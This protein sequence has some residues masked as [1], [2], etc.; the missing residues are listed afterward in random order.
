MEIK[1]RAPFDPLEWG[2]Y[3]D[4]RWR[5]LRAPW[6][7][8]RGSER[9][10]LEDKSIHAA[11]FMASTIVGVGRAHLNTPEEAQVRYMATENSYRS[12]GIGG[13]ILA[14]LEQKAKAQGATSIVLNAREKAR[15][16]YERNGYHVVGPGHTL[17]DEINHVVMRKQL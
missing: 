7:E 10:D 17:Y 1:I 12:K 6:N 15:E 2:A 4:L 3:F 13:K 11:A 5:E 14:H 16:F 8:P 9:D